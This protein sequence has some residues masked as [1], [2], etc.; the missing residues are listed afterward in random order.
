MQE[1]KTSKVFC[2]IDTDQLRCEEIG[3]GLPCLNIKR[4]SNMG[5]DEKTHL[6][7]LDHHDTYPTDIEKALNPFAFQTTLKT[8]KVD[9][10]YLTKNK[11]KIGGNSDFI[12]NFKN[13]DLDDFF[14]INDGENKIS[15]AKKYIEV[16]DNYE[17]DYENVDAIP[18]WINEIKKF[19]N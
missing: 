19:F 14:K 3:N 5:S 17:E 11:Y 16:S 6:L 7:N 8:L 12:K 10:K 18:S 1:E 2:I 4:L 9:E 15:F 13:L